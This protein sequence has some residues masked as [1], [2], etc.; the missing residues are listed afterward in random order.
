MLHVLHV[1]A[2]GAAQPAPEWSTTL[3]ALSIP[4]Y[5]V[6]VALYAA[7]YLLGRRLPVSHGWHR[8]H[9]GRQAKRGDERTPEAPR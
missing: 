6:L 5:G 7:G 4:L 9:A 1:L 8:D 2:T 3:L